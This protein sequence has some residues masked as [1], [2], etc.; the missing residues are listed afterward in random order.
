MIN[1]QYQMNCWKILSKNHNQ[2]V[3][4]LIVNKENINWNNYD[5]FYVTKYQKERKGKSR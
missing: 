1:H 5:I 3:K 4:D 2:N